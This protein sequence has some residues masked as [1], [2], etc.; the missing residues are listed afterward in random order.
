MKSNTSFWIYFEEVEFDRLISTDIENRFGETS[1]HD[2]PP[3]VTKPCESKINIENDGET[4]EY[5]FIS[6]KIVGLE[7]ISKD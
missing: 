6:T 4:K 1:L 3:L 5:R 7:E 2:L